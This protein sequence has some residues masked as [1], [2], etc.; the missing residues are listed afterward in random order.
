VAVR[1][2]VAPPLL[3]PDGRLRFTATPANSLVA[4]DVATGAVLWT[5]AARIPA[6]APSARWRVLSSDDGNS[7][8]VQSLSDEQGLTYQGTRRVDARTGAELA[9]DYKMEMY[10]YE[11]VV[12]WTALRS[13]G[14]LWMAVQ[15]PRDAGHW[16]RTM[17]PRTLRVLAD[18]QHPGPPA[19]RRQ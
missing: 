12:L 1:L 5:L 18:D 15:R 2:A 16:L 10:W 19:I 13:D 17:D 7:L 11:N 6:A 4:E 14:K 3:T 8:Y 9:N